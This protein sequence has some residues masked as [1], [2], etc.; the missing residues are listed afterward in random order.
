[1]TWD[2]KLLLTV[3]FHQDYAREAHVVVTTEML[4]DHGQRTVGRGLGRIDR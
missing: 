3:P 4:N 2:G 1:L